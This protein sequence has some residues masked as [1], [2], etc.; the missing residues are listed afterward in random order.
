MFV[1]KILKCHAFMFFSTKDSECDMPLA[2]VQYRCG[3]CNAA[4]VRTI[5]TQSDIKTILYQM[6]LSEISN[7]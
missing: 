6:M 7:D 2:H 4:H 3:S 5:K 1:I